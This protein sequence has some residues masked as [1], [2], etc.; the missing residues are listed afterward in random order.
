MLAGTILGMRAQRF[1]PSEHLSGESKDAVKSGLALIATLSALVLGLLVATTKGTYD[2]QSAA[3]KEFASNI[4][5]LD[6][7]LDK[8]GTEADKARKLLPSLVKA[9]LDHMWPE[10]S[11]RPVDQTASELRASGDALFDSV[12][13]LEPKNDA[14]R[15]LKSRALEI[16]IGMAQARQRMLAQKEDSIPTPFLVILSFW[17]TILFASYGLLAPRNATVFVVLVVCMISVAGALF[18]VLEMDRPFDG[19]IQVS[20]APLREAHSRVGH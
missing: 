4:A 6:R 7:V 19:M 2:T 17:L 8:Y 13:A 16:M 14:Q 15:L 11:A 5:L 9:S 1:L 3:V 20:D 18:L 10:N 12:S